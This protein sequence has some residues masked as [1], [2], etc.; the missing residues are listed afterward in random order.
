MTAVGPAGPTVVR[1][2][3]ASAPI[4]AFGQTALHVA[5]RSGCIRIAAQQ[6]AAGA[7]PAAVDAAGWTCKFAYNF[8]GAAA[9]P[10]LDRFLDRK[11]TILRG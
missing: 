9:P 2:A 1:A 3:P 10:C 11:L 4:A 8:D 5:A 7:D 6:L